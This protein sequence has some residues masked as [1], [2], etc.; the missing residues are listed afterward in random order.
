MKYKEAPLLNADRLTEIQ[1][2]GH[3]LARLRLARQIRQEDAATR[4]GISRSTAALIE[5]GDPGR[6]MGQ[7]LRYLDAIAPG[8]PFLALWQESD[9][10]LLALALKERSQRARPLSEAALAELDF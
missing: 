9:P 5:K 6:T 4:A 8:L 2:L 7:L 10:S 3:K 1:L